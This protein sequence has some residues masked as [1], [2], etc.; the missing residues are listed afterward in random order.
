MAS[1]TTHSFLLSLP[2]Y[3]AHQDDSL[4]SLYSICGGFEHALLGRNLALNIEFTLACP[5]SPFGLGPSG[6]GQTTGLGS[7]QFVAQSYVRAFE[8][9]PYTVLWTRQRVDSFF[10]LY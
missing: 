9:G 8:L 2:A 5:P 3:Y 1:S 10:N 4:I 7:S 6:V